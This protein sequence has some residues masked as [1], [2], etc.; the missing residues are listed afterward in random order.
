MTTAVLSKT[1]FRKPLLKLIDAAVLAPSGDNTQPWSFVV[2][3]AKPRIEIHLEETRDR[4]PMNAG[5]RM[6]RI[7]IGAAV[8]NIL[9]TAQQN[10]YRSE[11]LHPPTALATICLSGLPAGDVNVDTPGVIRHRVTNR[12]M[13]DGKPVSAETLASLQV[14]TAP[15]AGVHTHW[16]CEP[17]RL[18]V[19][20]QVIGRA[21][22]H[23]FMEPTMRNAFLS[24]VRFDVPANAPVQ[25]GL[26]VGSLELS[27]SD[28]IAM[29]LMRRLPLWLLKA[30]PLRR[31]FARYAE[32]LVG[33]AAGLCVVTACDNSPGTDLLVGQAAQRAW[34]AITEHHLAAQPMM[35]LPVLENAV[36][37]GSRALN[38]AL[39]LESVHAL[40]RQ[41]GEHLTEIGEGRPAFVLRFGTAPPPTA[42]TGRMNSDSMTAPVAPAIPG[43]NGTAS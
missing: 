7:A 30:M 8:E 36:E 17:D 31:T 1:S 5:Q 6:A 13:Y 33:S 42:R 38:D 22:A 14:A 18:R 26:P 11:L 9:R 10:G 12:R 20:A 15:L 23:M 25:S 35:S 27:A 21:D 4:S 37:H 39:D 29:R 34:L 3:P 19:L 43:Q 28:R 2:D 24:Q 40:S 41:F 32:Q 16:I